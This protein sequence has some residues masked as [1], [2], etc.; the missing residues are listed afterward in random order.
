MLSMLD[1]KANSFENN[2]LSLEEY[3]S[4]SGQT[5]EHKLWLL[6]QVSKDD[7]PSKPVKC[8]VRVSPVLDP[9]NGRA[10]I[11]EPYHVEYFVIEFVA[12]GKEFDDTSITRRSAVSFS[13]ANSHM[14]VVA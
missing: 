6:P 8:T 2:E 12:D 9:Y 13:E 11:I 10:S 3:M 1:T 4:Y 7:A 5:G 14:G